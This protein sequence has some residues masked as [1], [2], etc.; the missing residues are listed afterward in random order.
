MTDRLVATV[1]HVKPHG[2]VPLRGRSRRSVRSCLEAYA[3]VLLLIA[4]VAFFAIYP[5]TS[6]TFVSAANIR[7]MLGGNAVVA[8]S[9]I[10]V[11]IPLIAYE[12]D[13]SVGATTALTS[14]FVAAGLAAGIAVPIVI[15]I[16]VGLGALVGAINAILVTRAGINA[17]IATLGIA[18][19]ISGVM[20]LK[21]GGATVTGNIPATVTDFGSG[22]TLGIPQPAWALFAVAILAYYILEYTPYGRY[23]YTLGSNRQA[24]KLVGIRTRVVLGLSFVLAGLVASTAGALQVARAGSGDPRIAETLTL[25]ALAAAFLSAAAIKPGR[26]NVAGTLVAL[27]FLAVLNNGLNIAGA[28]VYVNNFVNGGA[29]IIGVALAVRLGRRE[30]L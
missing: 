16:G 30:Q 8:I 20:D 11:L 6:E 12:F 1:D 14:I 28:E 26:F 22:T 7:A 10:A 15:A 29:L 18:I 5:A 17:V 21:T 24:A 3:F 9:A 13:L 19:I 4:A 2:S 27:L 25:P 23:L